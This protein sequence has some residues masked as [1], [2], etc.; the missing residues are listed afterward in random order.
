[1]A[2][3]IINGS[4]VVFNNVFVTINGS[5]TDIQGYITGL[6][7]SSSGMADH[8]KTNTIDGSVVAVN[9]LIKAPQGTLTFS[10]GA[11]TTF[12]SFLNNRFTPFT[13]QIKYFV[14]GNL[15]GA[16]QSITIAGALFSDEAIDYK[17]NDVQC[18]ITTG[19][20]ACTA[21]FLTI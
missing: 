13:L 17:A 16:N 7:I 10:P 3:Q 21:Q 12:Y 9:P 15:G 1:M 4:A 19:F 20:K 2:N 6:N 11:F 5:E 8:V 18:E 14:L